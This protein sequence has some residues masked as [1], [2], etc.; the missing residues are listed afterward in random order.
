MNFETISSRLSRFNRRRKKWIF[1]KRAFYSVKK[2][3]TSDFG[4]LI[5]GA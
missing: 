4:M 2:L 3:L 5:A 1:P